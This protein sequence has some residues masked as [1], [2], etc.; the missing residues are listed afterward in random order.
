MD[1]PVHYFINGPVAPGH[2]DQVR[3]AIRQAAYD[4]GRGARTGGRKGFHFHSLA[5]QQVE[6]AL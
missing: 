3:A 6:G 2:Q 1:H 4:L 5:R